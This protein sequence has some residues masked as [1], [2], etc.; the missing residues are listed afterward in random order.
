MRHGSHSAIF[1]LVGQCCRLAQLLRLDH[2][3]VKETMSALPGAQQITEAESRRRLMW[4]CFSLDVI[5]GSGVEALLLGSKYLPNIQLPR[6]A[7][8]FDRQIDSPTAV[9]D[10]KELL[11]LQTITFTMGIEA[12]FVQVMWLRSQVLRLI[13][14][15]DCR[16]LPWSPTSSFQLLLAQIE[17][18]GLSIPGH[19]EFND[20]NSYIHLQQ[21]QLSAFYLLHLLYHQCYCDLLRITLP[22][23]TFPLAAT[24][25]NAP[26]GFVDSIRQRC[27]KETKIISNIL[28]KGLQQVVNPFDDP[29]CA[30]CAYEATK[31]QI[32][33]VSTCGGSETQAWDEVARDVLANLTVLRLLRSDRDS[34]APLL[35]S[36]FDL[37]HRFGFGELVSMLRT[38][39]EI[40]ENK[41][42]AP[43]PHAEHL[44]AASTFRLAWSEISWRKPSEPIIPVEAPRTANRISGSSMPVAAMLTP[45][46]SS[47]PSTVPYIPETNFTGQKHILPP[48]S[49]V[50]MADS[51]NGYLT[52][53]PLVGQPMQ[54]SERPQPGYPGRSW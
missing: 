18:F 43:P 10:P 27:Y 49:Y 52:W 8:D 51:M 53:D 36:L 23:Y 9:L 28:K 34:L 45:T 33:F 21:H 3:P 47:S 4:S 29:L 15:T 22:G 26:P 37:L 40:D 44:H 42:I 1:M 31:I 54:G 17:S 50:Q 24:F 48:G 25:N 39:G 11:S 19:L 16:D 20:I 35:K 5:I 46:A 12:C 2:E 32:I 6:Q 14:K 30:A 41:E 7:A 38:E 13:R